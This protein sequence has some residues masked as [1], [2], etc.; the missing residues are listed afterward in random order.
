MSAPGGPARQ[1]A[2]SCGCTTVGVD[3]TSAY[4]DTA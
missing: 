3:V 4:V 2:R 1:I